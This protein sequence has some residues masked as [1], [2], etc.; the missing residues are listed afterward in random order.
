MDDDKIIIIHSHC[1]KG[2]PLLLRLCVSRIQLS[3]QTG[4]WA[5]LDAVL[6]AS[7]A[8]GGGCMSGFTQL[9]LI[10]REGFETFWKALMCYEWYGD[11]L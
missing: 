4:L 5:S 9:I 10:S 7:K 8:T 11:P 2:C 6:G 1:W 3:K